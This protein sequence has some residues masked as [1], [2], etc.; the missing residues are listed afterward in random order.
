MIPVFFLSAGLILHHF[1]LFPALL[2]L[3]GRQ[4]RHDPV[5]QP[6]TDAELPTVS[7][8]VTCCN[9]GE[10]I[11]DKAVNLLAQDY[12]SEK[13]QIVF[14]V[15]GAEYDVPTMLKEY[16]SGTDFKVVAFPAQ[17]GKIHVLNDAVSHCQGEILVLTDVGARFAPDTLRQLAEAFTDPQ[18]GGVCGAHQVERTTTNDA[19]MGGAQSVYWR[20][21]RLIKRAESR[22]GSITASDGPIYAIRRTLYTPIPEAVSD[23]SFQ[24]MAIVRQGWRFVFAPEAQAWIRPRSKSFGHEITRRRRVVVRSLHGL[25][26]SREL[27]N[28]R[29]YGI[30]S[31]SLLSGKILRRVLPLLLITLLVSSAF[32]APRGLVWSMVFGAQAL[33]Y[34]LALSK[35]AGLRLESKLI[36]KVS[37]VQDMAGYF[38]A[39]QI[40]TLLGLLDFLRGKRVDRWKPASD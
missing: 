20:F 22:L 35:P 29:R 27:L 16:L 33:C 30:Y 34:L 2:L 32:L 10:L 23:D 37:S 40:G 17:R 25:W 4:A 7:V 28:A 15:D 14:A 31:L 5:R 19:S 39:G 11:R 26:L 36:P 12:P 8:M 6:Q 24:A 38:L 9:E 3:L 21:D 13:R 1:L 18:V